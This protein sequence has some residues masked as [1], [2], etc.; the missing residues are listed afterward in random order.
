MTRVFSFGQRTGSPDSARQH[1][2]IVGN[3]AAAQEGFVEQV[4]IG[5][6]TLEVEVDIG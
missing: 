2:R 4:A 6:L 1:L 5:A 3:A